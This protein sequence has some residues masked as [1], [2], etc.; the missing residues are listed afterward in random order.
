MFLARDLIRYACRDVATTPRTMDVHVRRLAT[1]KHCGT[2]QLEPAKPV[3]LPADHAIY[4]RATLG[5]YHVASRPVGD[6]L[7]STDHGGNEGM[8]VRKCPAAEGLSTV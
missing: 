2:H 6:A 8:D 4:P 1:I 7:C 3:C 5:G